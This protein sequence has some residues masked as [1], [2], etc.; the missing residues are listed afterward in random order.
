M[1]KETDKLQ[2]RAAFQTI[3]GKNL[4]VLVDRLNVSQ[5]CAIAAKEASCIVGC[6]SKSA[7]SRSREVV[8]PLA[9]AFVFSLRFPNTRKALTYRW[10]GS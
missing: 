6:I 10:S 4:E 9:V 5:L 7:T 3:A 8:L 1:R 2:D